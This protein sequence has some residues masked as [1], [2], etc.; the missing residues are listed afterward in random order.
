MFMDLINL[1]IPGFVGIGATEL[2]LILLIVVVLFGAT[3]LPKLGEGLGKGIKNFKDALKG[4]DQEKKEIKTDQEKKEIN[5][6][7]NT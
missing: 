3:R 7:E 5:P 2:V 4:E 6:P 1:F